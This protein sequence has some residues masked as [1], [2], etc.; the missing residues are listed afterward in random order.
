MRI[1]EPCPVKQLYEGDPATY[2][3]GFDNG[4]LFQNAQL[5]SGKFCRILKGTVAGVNEQRIEEVRRDVVETWGNIDN[6]NAEAAYL[7]AHPEIAKAVHDC[8]VRAQL[9][10]CAIHSS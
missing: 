6:P 5:L 2:Q 1:C 10:N 9:G 7:E 4:L 3:E 8:E